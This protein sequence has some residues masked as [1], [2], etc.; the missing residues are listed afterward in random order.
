[1][2]LKYIGISDGPELRF[3]Q[4]HIY[5]TISTNTYVCPSVLRPSFRHKIFF[6]PKSPW[7]HPLTPGVDPRGWPRVPPWHAVPPKE[8][9]YAHEAGIF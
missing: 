7:D 2:F 3:A 6:S 8:L 1:M 4:I 9:E 5:N